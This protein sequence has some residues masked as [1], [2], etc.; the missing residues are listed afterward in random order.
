MLLNSHMQSLK[1]RA[2][3]LK[4]IRATTDQKFISLTTFHELTLKVP[5]SNIANIRYSVEL[6]VVF[7]V[8]FRARLSLISFL[9]HITILMLDL[10]RLSATPDLLWLEQNVCLLIVLLDFDFLLAKQL[11]FLCSTFI[12]LSFISLVFKQ[13]ALVLLELN[14]IHCTV[15]DWAANWPWTF[16]P[17]QRSLFDVF[18]ETTTRWFLFITLLFF[19]H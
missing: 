2:V 5:S 7:W 4:L 3:H 18:L 15:T 16:L 14:I 17:L 1:R 11:L 13:A 19:E 9:N 10:K 12:R 6:R 8:I